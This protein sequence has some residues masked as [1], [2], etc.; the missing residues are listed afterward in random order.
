MTDMAFKNSPVPGRPGYAWLEIDAA[1][2][3]D[4]TF[5]LSCPI[6]Q[7]S[8]IWLAPDGWQGSPYDWKPLDIEGAA[9]GARLLVGPPIVDRLREDLLVKIEIPAANYRADSLWEYVPPSGAPLPDPTVEIDDGASGDGAN[10]RWVPP[11]PDPPPRPR[12][13]DAR[14]VDARSADAP[15]ASEARNGGSSVGGAR[16]D[17]GIKA[18]TETNTGPRTDADTTAGGGTTGEQSSPRPDHGA[19]G[20][21][22]IALAAVL[23]GLIIGLVLGYL[24]VGAERAAAVSALTASGASAEEATRLLA[25]REPQAESLYRVG[26]ALREYPNGSRDIALQ[27]IRRAA[28]LG[29]APAQLWLARSADPAREEWKGVRAKPDAAIALEG[30]AHVVQAGNND[31]AVNRI[32]LCGYMQGVSQATDAERQVVTTYC[33]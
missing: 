14:P 24:Y 3:R 15:G 1:V 9:T 2:S 21:K 28:E 29:Y 10:V 30:Y 32:T 26:M 27:A 6:R 17:A 22:L 11:R 20:G 13:G 25:S 4:V 7:P 33:H 23:I 31:A 19:K 18:T 8:S 12:P 5:R 16:A